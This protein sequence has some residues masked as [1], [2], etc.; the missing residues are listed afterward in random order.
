MVTLC[1]ESCQGL[2]P[3]HAP[4]TVRATTTDRIDNDIGLIDYSFG[5]RSAVQAAQAALHSAEVEAKGNMPNGIG[6]VKLMGRS[7]G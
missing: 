2:I 6:V 1:A 4:H 5:F 7:S 3:T